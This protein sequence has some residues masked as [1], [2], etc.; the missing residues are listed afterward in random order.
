M[1][2]PADG[3]ATTI[4]GRGSGP[5]E[6]GTM[7]TVRRAAVERFRRDY[8]GGLGLADLADAGRIEIH[9]PDVAATDRN[10]RGWRH[11]PPHSGIFRFGRPAVSPS[12]SVASSQSSVSADNSASAST[13]SAAR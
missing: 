11:L 4:G 6:S 2:N 13:A 10:C 1:R 7:T 3:A 8:D 12:A 5:V 9:S